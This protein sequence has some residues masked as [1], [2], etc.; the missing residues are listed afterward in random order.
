MP[1]SVPS[2]WYGFPAKIAAP[3]TIVLKAVWSWTAKAAPELIPLS[4]KPSLNLRFRRGNALWT[5]ASSSGCRRGGS[6][7]TTH[8]EQQLQH[9]GRG[10]HRTLSRGS[11]PAQA[12]ALDRGWLGGHCWWE[13]SHCSCP[14]SLPA[15]AG[16]GVCQ[17]EAQLDYRITA[18][19]LVELVQLYD[20]MVGIP[21]NLRG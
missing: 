14:S 5:C 7:R 10:Q 16:C 12:W 6:I 17:V 2:Q 3:L 9:C 18:L 1:G 19:L 8:E 21:T 13:G 20:C 15:A 4:A 11:L